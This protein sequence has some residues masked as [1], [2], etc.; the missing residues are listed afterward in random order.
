L[1][2]TWSNVTGLNSAEPRIIIRHQLKRHEVSRGQKERKRNGEG[3]YLGPT[4]TSQERTIALAPLFADALRSHKERQESNSQVEGWKPPE[5][6]LRDL[7][8]LKA[9]GGLI[10]PNQDN[11]DWHEILKRYGFEYWRGHLNR[12]ITAVWLARQ[13]NIDIRVVRAILGHESE[14][15]TYYYAADIS[16]AQVPAM[17]RYGAALGK[18]IGRS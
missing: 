7:V 9:N 8:F 18:R 16:K 5:G 11:E 13:P 17:K 12:H 2:L 15:M 3:W 1:G 14:A 10:T 4:K 6:E